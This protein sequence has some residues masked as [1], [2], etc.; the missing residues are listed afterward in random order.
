MRGGQVWMIETALEKFLDML[1]GQPHL[2]PPIKEAIHRHRYEEQQEGRREEMTVKIPRRLYQRFEDYF[3]MLG[4]TSWF[5]RT[6]VKEVNKQ[7]DGFILEER[8]EAAVRT[9]CVEVGSADSHS[10]DTVPS[11]E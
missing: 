1:D 6:L 3:P 11:G 10:S 9:I 5:I 8:V 7:L 4:A 2:I